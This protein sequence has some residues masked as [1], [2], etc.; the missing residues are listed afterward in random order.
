[1]AA[2]GSIDTEGSPLPFPKQSPSPATD[3]PKHVARLRQAQAHFARGELRDAEALCERVL[4][5]RPSDFDALYLLAGVRHALG[6]LPEALDALGRAL[7]VNPRSPQILVN[8]GLLLARL[9]RRDEAL[10][11][12]D[13]ATAIGADFAEAHNGRGCVLL[14][15][16]RPGEALL[17]FDR[18]LAVKPADAEALSNRGSALITLHRPAEALSSCDRAL[19]LRP[20]D[21]RA[22]CNRAH[23]LHRLGRHAE[24]LVGY[25]AVL[26][27]DRDHVGATN[28]R[29]AALARL[30]AGGADRPLGPAAPELRA[31]D[32]DSR[33][34]VAWVGRGNAKVTEGRYREAVADYDA[35]IAIDRNNV[36][37]WT[38][39]GVALQH[40]GRIA[41]A[42]ASHDRALSLEP[43]CVNA[44]DNR[45][46]ALFLQDRTIEAIADYGR[47]LEL[48][49]H[50]VGTLCNR[51][52]ALRALGRIDEATADLDRALAIDPAFAEARFGRSTIRLLRGDLRGAWPDYESRLKVREFGHWRRTFDKP[53][54][55]G[56]P[57]DGRTLLLHAEQGLGD[58]IQFLRYAR[59][60]AAKARV[61]LEVQ[62]PLLRLAA[63]IGE[64]AEVVAAGEHLPDFDLHCPLLSLPLAFD[65]TLETIP[66]AVPY[67]DAD[68][69]QV[70]Q[71]RRR[72]AGLPGL[73]VGL[74]WAGGFRPE[75]PIAHAMDRRR[76]VTL[77][78]FA[79]FAGMPGVS[80]V[81]LQKDGPAAQTKS[82]L[83]GLVVHDFTDE[84]GDFADTAA[85]V[86]ALDLVISVDTSVAHLAGALGKPVWLLNRFDSEWRWLLDRNDS[87]WYPTLRQFRHA[88]PGEWEPVLS[89]VRDALAG[90]AA[91]A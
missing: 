53:R 89:R 12:Y 14:D 13:R 59:L 31:M 11:S 45:A 82:P 27:I 78:H 72:L 30:A 10:A 56:E 52:G 25:A 69:A 64:V 84:L 61:V 63:R 77:A 34:V 35:A 83:D 41:E 40:E 28:G 54:W 32:A 33:H 48:E 39:R 80:F 58:T 55:A 24:A 76:S 42:L 87:P 70:A 16:N 68:A 6:K 20:R 38:N 60:V 79:G 17:S 36:D 2:S 51:S 86:T 43:R 21:V 75:L 8:R 3:L 22:L 57:I 67:L 66:R 9:G 47:A 15:M 44:W 62:R 91:G 1:M 90:L 65:T 50:R 74:A 46:S 26:A 71:W 4:R 18:A 49:P 37:A 73:K 88:R 81:S 5:K 23:A 19:A 7:R 29:E 85:L